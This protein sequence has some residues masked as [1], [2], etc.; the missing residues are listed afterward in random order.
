[1]LLTEQESLNL[2]F[3]LKE[4]QFAC[5]KNIADGRD[6]IGIL[7]IGYGKPSYTQFSLVYPASISAGTC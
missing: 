2:E 1:M 3:A 7:P 4:K 5:I 6:V